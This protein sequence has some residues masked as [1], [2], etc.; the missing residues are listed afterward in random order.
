MLGMLVPGYILRKVGLIKSEST[1]SFVALLLWVCAPMLIFKSLIYD[2]KKI[3]NPTSS[4]LL[5][6]LALTFVLGIVV[7]LVVFFVV[8]LMFLGQKERSAANANIFAG[9]FGNVG[10]I[11]IPFIAYVL[12]GNPI[13]PYALFYSAIFNV[14]FNTL[15]WTLGVYIITGDIKSMRPIKI[16]AN[17]IVIVTAIAL[18]LFFLRV[19]LVKYVPPLAEIISFL[20]AMTTPLSMIIVGIRFAEIKIKSIF[21]DGWVYLSAFARLVAAPLLAFGLVMLL[22][23]FGIFGVVG[24]D[25]Y[26]TFGRA[27]CLVLIILSALPAAAS[28]IAFCER[29]NGNTVCA[30]KSFMLSTFLSI[31]TMPLLIPLLYSLL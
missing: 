14:V 3:A 23:I 27:V 4:S 25:F 1:K 30:V 5:I 8:K 12:A 11:G 20:G 9:T 21:T 29:N 13:L 22:R 16:I 26:N 18:P 28:T 24:G 7:L 6:G 2:E 17:P 15:C 19:D 10:F 31:I